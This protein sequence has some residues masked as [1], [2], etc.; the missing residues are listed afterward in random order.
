MVSLRGLRLMIKI[1]AKISRKEKFYSECYKRNINI[2]NV[3]EDDDYIYFVIDEDD[4]NKIKSIWFVK[5]VSKDYCGYKKWFKNK[6]LVLC[7]SIV[8]IVFF[9]SIIFI[10][11]YIIKVQIIHENSE[12]KDMLYESL[13][14][15]GIKKNSWKKDYHELQDI[16]DRILNEY[17]DRIEWIEIENKGLTYIVRLEERKINSVKDEDDYCNVYAI[18]DGIIKKAI[19]ESGVLLYDVNDFVHKGD[20]LITGDIK[21]N[22]EVVSRVC[23]NGKVYAEVWYVVSVNIPIEKEVLTRTGKKRYN[24]KMISSFYNDYLFKN[25][26][27]D[28]EEEN[29]RIF[30]IFNVSLYLSKQYEVIKDKVKYSEEELQK[31]ALEESKKKVEDKLENDEKIIYQKVLKKE[32]NNS[33]MNIEVFIT[34]LEQIGTLKKE[35][36]EVIDSGNAINE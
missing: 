14:D 25:R 33:T 3:V 30:K 28:Y 32:E 2:Y 11:N 29:K 1:K 31:I 10:N 35:R 21:H 13:K 36:I 12:L 19:Y 20:I 24:V 18:K 15:L 5:I 9:F 26:L 27:I 8:V 4:Y 16:K 6:S 23:A 22:D 34:V 17:K 7:I